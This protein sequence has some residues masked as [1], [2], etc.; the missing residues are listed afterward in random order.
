MKTLVILPGWGG[1]KE[2]WK[3]FASLASKDFEVQ[4]IDL[5]CFGDEKWQFRQFYGWFG[6]KGSVAESVV[7]GCF[8]LRFSVM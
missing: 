6:L 1:N 4:I 5:P 2:T 8:F 7:G 3:E